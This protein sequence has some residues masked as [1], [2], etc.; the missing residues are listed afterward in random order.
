MKKTELIKA[1]SI[2]TGIGQKDVTSIF[3]SIFIQISEDLKKGNEVTVKDF[4]TF[5]LETR[6]ARKG[7]NPQ[8]GEVID[9]PEKQVVKFKPFKNVLNMKWL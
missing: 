2:D 8:T 5:K 7:R 1:V 3:D 9:I 4:G 6:S